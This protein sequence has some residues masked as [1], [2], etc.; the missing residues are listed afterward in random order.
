MIIGESVILGKNLGSGDQNR[1]I[2]SFMQI[3]GTV[4]EEVKQMHNESLEGLK[5]G[6]SAKWRK[7]KTLQ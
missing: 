7:S 3:L 2:S 4:I 6:D 5:A 1:S